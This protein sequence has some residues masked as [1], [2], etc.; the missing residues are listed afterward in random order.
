MD[1]VV[2]KVAMAICS[3]LVI[4]VLVGLFTDGA[5]LGG[6][7]DSGHVLDEFCDL[8]DRAFL[9]GSSIVW[10]TPFLPSGESV[11]ISIHNGIVLV[12]SSEG[13]AARQPSCGLHLWRSD[14]RCMNASTVTSM[15]DGAGSLIFESG[16]TVEIAARI[17][18]YESEPRVFVFVYLV[19]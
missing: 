16:Q 9:G 6:N 10:Q 2:S 12:E 14:G 15:D 11:T 5:F 1:F 8:T 17:L 18:T 19:D 3:L 4:T 13:A 7:S